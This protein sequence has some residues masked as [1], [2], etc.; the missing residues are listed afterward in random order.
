MH[1]H[2]GVIRDIESANAGV[3]RHGWS[4]AVSEAAV[5]T[6]GEAA[7]RAPSRFVGR[8]ESKLDAKG[9]LSVPADFRRALGDGPLYA[10]ASLT[11]PVVECG[12]D[13][14]ISLQLDVIASLDVYD[15]DRWAM[16][17]A[18]TEDTQRLSF[19]DNGRVIVPAILRDHAGLSGQVGFAG[20][21]QRFVMAQPAWL[22][23]RRS[24]GRAAAARHR[25]TIKARSLASVTARRDA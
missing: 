25:D 20:R 19:D 8:A 15:E 12:G 14:L 13:D 2:D 1:R 9:R 7:I 11:D 24:A 22:A 4:A 16:E 3:A 5:R 17:E 21:G 23:E 6:R 18:V 10:C